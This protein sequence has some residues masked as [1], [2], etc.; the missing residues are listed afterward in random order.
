[1]PRASGAHRFLLE[2]DL[3]SGEPSEVWHGQG[4]APDSR[5]PIPPLISIT[6]P[7]QDLIHTCSPPSSQPLHAV[8]LAFLSGHPRVLKAGMLWGGARV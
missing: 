8:Y 2:P 4:W 5:F 3:P 7:V 6:I 1:M